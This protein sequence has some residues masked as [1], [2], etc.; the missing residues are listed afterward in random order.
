MNLSDVKR[1]I[2]YLFGF[3]EEGAYILFDE[4]LSKE[5]PYYVF[6]L[7]KYIWAIL[8]SDFELCNSPNDINTKLEVIKIKGKYAYKL[9]GPEIGQSILASV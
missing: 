5:T 9:T 1:R 3:P 8:K 6:R 7:D 2:V 4:Q